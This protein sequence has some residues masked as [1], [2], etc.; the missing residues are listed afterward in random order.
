MS[1]SCGE[2]EVAL[3]CCKLLEVHSFACFNL[4]AAYSNNSVKF[5]IEMRQQVEKKLAAWLRLLHPNGL[6]P[7]LGYAASLLIRGIPVCVV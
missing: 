4:V 6:P 5:A 2:R 1:S 3:A 7:K